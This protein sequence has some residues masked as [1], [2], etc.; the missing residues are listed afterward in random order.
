MPIGQWMMLVLSRRYSILPAFASVT[1]RATSGGRYRPSG[2]ASGPSGRE[3]GKTADNAHHIRGSDDNVE[4]KPVFLLDALDEVGVADILG[5]GLTG[6]SRAVVLCENED[7]DGLAGAVGE[8]DGAA[9]L[10]VGVTGVDAEL[11]M[12][13][14]SLVEFCLASFT[15]DSN[16]SL[17][18]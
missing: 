3:H 15:T 6:G 13:F 11:N 12:D 10:L 14:D 9:N 2:S 17:G 8:N 1:A 16:A 7:A 5:A 4:I 18:S